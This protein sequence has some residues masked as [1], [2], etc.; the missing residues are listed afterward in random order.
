METFIN[1]Y[2]LVVIMTNDKLEIRAQP[3]NNTDIKPLAGEAAQTLVYTI[4]R[5]HMSQVVYVTEALARD[6]GALDRAYHDMG[7]ALGLALSEGDGSAN[8]GTTLAEIKLSY[9]KN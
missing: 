6:R 4:G 9:R 2:Q 1:H 8:T 3:L 5:R 7:E